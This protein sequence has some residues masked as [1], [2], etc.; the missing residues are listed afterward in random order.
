ML[1]EAKKNIKLMFISFKYNLAKEMTNRGSFIMQI[2][3]MILNNSTF[4]IQWLILF[5]L[6]D[7]IGGYSFKDIMILWALTASSYGLSHIFFQNVYEIPKLIANGKLDV[8]LT[9]PKNVLFNIAISKTSPSAIGDIIFGY[10]ILL[11]MSP[12]NIILF[13]VFTITGAIIFSA[14]SV[15]VGSLTFWLKRGDIVADRLN[16]LMTLPSTYPEG[17]FN[18]VVRILLYIL[19]PVG[20][21]VFLPI[22]IL[23]GFNILFFIAVILFTILI[24]FLAFYIFH[25]GLKR[26]TSSNLMSAR[27]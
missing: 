27:V 23:G 11:I 20:F 16:S 22:R 4:I 19:I 9:Q 18:G 17:I 5:S 13:T 12:G 7:S 25:K 15:I 3:F 10:L 26:Y 2:V 1:M 14:F 24:T 6:K 21:M 8:Y